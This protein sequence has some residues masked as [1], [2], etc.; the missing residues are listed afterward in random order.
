M[1]LVFY[2]NSPANRTIDL[3]NLQRQ[4]GYRNSPDIR[5]IGVIERRCPM[6]NDLSVAEASA[7]L[8]VD[9]SFVRR[10]LRSGALP[11]RHLGRAWVVS[12]EAL[13]DLQE[14]RVG[15]GRPLSPRRAWAL[16]SILEG[17][18]P[19]W[20]S[21][22][23]RSQVRAQLRQLC[24]ADAR[25][26]RGELRSRERRY[27]VSGHRSA[28]ARLAAL[29]DAWPAGVGVASSVGADLVVAEAIPEFYLPADRWESISSKLHLAPASG[30]PDAYVRV[31]RDMW[32]FGSEGPGRA[33]LAASLVDSGDWRA[34]RAGADVLNDL[35]GEVLG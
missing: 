35:A 24:G 5:T 20:I 27:P 33:A 7:A 3:I 14:R 2:R 30:S 10:M 28:I 15:A 11:G 25:V 26:W 18:R 29:K 13:A 6:A 32:P 9:A 19:D 31:P 1:R 16:L 8:G 4:N 22:V 34:A 23:A 17:G 21:A 12:G